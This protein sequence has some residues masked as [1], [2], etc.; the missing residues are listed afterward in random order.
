MITN[1][2][3]RI[4]NRRKTQS[5]LKDENEEMGK[6]KKS[7]LNVEEYSN[8]EKGSSF[9]EKLDK[10][11]KTRNLQNHTVLKNNIQENVKFSEVTHF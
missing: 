3:Q 5:N 4:I 2:H 7:I 10:D 11:Q 9:M 1:D 6:M 8:K